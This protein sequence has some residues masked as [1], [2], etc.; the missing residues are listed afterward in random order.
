MKPLAV[1]H[2][3]TVTH[4]SSVNPWGGHMHIYQLSASRIQAYSY[5]PAGWHTPGLIRN[6]VF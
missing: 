1:L 2:K 5:Q 3:S 4:D 6:S